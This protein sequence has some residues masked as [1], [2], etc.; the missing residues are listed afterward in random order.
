[1]DDVEDPGDRLA[2]RLPIDRD[3]ASAI[4]AVARENGV[5]LLAAGLAF[6]TFNALIPLVLFLLIGTT[7]FGWLEVIL[8]A[9]E[10][11]AGIEP[12]RVLEAIEG[13]IGDGAGRSNAA[14]IAAVVFV[15]SVFTMFQSVNVAFGHVYDI[16]AQ[17][18]IIATIRDTLLVLGTVVIAVLLLLV[19]NVVLIAV[20]AP[21]VATAA[22]IPLI[23]VG[24]FAVF[25]PMF[26]TFSPEDVG[27]RELLPGAVLAAV[28]VAVCA[29][30]F[31]VYIVVSESVQLYGIA[32][33]VL[34]LL[35]WLYLGALGLL[36]GVV[37]NAVL[38]DR[39]EPPE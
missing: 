8:R 35:T 4:V 29:V 23:V 34:L 25:L 39:V 1:M 33:G 2:A 26:A 38:A 37:V 7:V 21:G 19:V 15:W 12:D 30:G 24:L 28:T 22:T 6:Y 36:G 17:R 16:R 32:G 10:P 27:L 14:A 11:I 13:V 5:T 20:T 3:E 31:R 9:I 18:S